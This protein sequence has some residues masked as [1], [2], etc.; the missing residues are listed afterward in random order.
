MKKVRK[1]MMKKVMKKRTTTRPASQ[2][3]PDRNIERVRQ[4]LARLTPFLSKGKA[5]A[6][7]T[8]EGF[9]LETE[10]MISE[11]FGETSEMLEA[12]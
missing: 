12:Y 9:D 8:L 3:S 11:L 2:L 10:R 6:T 4:Q 5:N 1:K 7:S